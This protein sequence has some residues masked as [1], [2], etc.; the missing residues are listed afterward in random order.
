[1]EDRLLKTPEIMEYLGISV[2]T[3]NVLANS[4][5]IPV[6][7][8]GGS[9]RADMEVLRNWVKEQGIPEPTPIPKARGR[10]PQP[11]GG[12]KVREA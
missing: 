5:K 4:G 7:K 11:Q 1:M 12:Y 3:F 10:K 2:R 9:W 8:I 6:F